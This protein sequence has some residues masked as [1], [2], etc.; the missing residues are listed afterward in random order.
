MKTL[1]L[2][3]VLSNTFDLYIAFP[4]RKLELFMR[5]F[6]SITTILDQILLHE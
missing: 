5:D 6:I 4:I 1:F 2:A 3:V